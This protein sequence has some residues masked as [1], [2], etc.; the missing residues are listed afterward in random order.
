MLFA[1]VIGAFTSVHAIMATRTSQGAIAWAVSLN[2]LPYVAVPAYFVFGRNQ[3]EGYAI[4]R[5]KDVLDLLP[6]AQKLMVDLAKHRAAPAGNMVDTR[7]LETIAKVP[8]TGGN[9]ADLLVDGKATFDAIFAAIDAAQDYILVQFYIIKD[10]GLGNTLKEKLLARAIAGV[11]VLVLY[12]EIGSHK[13]PRTYV[14]ELRA[15]GVR[16]H[17]FD[18]T[19]GRANR[20][21]LNF[22]NHRKIVIVD[23]ET[24]FIGGHNVGDE[25]L[26]LDP[27]TSPWR[28]TH[29]A[30]RG[31]VVQTVQIPFGEDWHWSTGEI[32]RDLDWTPQPAPHGDM[33]ALCIPSGPADTFETCALFFLDAINNAQ[34]RIWIASPYF[35]P[36]EQIISALQIAALRGV[37][38]RILIPET[39]DSMLVYLSSFS[40][41]EPCERAGVQIFRYAPGFLHQKVI[42]VDDRF[43]AVG[44]AN[45]DNR[46]FRL[47]FEVTAA[48]EDEFFASQVE[49]MLLDDFSKSTLASASDLTTRSFPF[50]LAVRV[51]RLLAPVQ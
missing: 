48:I 18:S 40:Y 11:R 34:E 1:H 14:D 15:G 16:I 19:K 49:A 5:R 3:F 31:P 51:A 12:D 23:G 10:D 20:F 38:V 7:F 46:S 44:T 37:E 30:L 41:L 2:T 25:Y 9:D 33:K 45:F 26:G 8:V 32:L 36:D 21:Q 39:P 4:A 28:D 6:V 47:N 43:S 24:A 13:L 42:L 35:V 50:R 29:V 27:K 22:R 17:R